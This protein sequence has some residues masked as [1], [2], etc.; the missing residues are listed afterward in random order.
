VLFTTG[1]VLSVIAD[2]RDPE[3]AREREKEQKREQEE[4]KQRQ[5]ERRQR[6]EERD[7]EP[8]EAGSS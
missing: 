2:K 8:A 5:E 4:R 3:G 7:A 6:Q 1:I